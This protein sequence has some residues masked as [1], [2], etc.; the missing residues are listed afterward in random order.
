[1]QTAYYKTPN[2]IQHTGTLVDLDE[3]R[4]KTAAAQRDSLARQPKAAYLPGEPETWAEEPAF[5]P[6]VLTLSPEERRRARREH[7]AWG[8]DVCA[9]LAVILT[10]AV[11]LL[12]MLL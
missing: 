9:S 5:C 12:R 3:F 8:L 10:T 11:F 1:M 2:F 4:R 7:R 6:V